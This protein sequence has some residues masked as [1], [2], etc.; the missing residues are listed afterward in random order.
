MGSERGPPGSV[1]TQDSPPVF[2]LQILCF[3]G[4]LFTELGKKRQVLVLLSSLVFTKPGRAT[5]VNSGSALY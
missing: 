3:P 5:R 1:A 2:F 4:L